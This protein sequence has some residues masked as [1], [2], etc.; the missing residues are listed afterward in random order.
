MV[1]QQGMVPICIHGLA[2]F[3]NLEAKCTIAS[4]PTKN[5]QFGGKSWLFHNKMFRPPSIRV[6]W[7]QGSI[8]NDIFGVDT[9]V[10]FKIGF[11]REKEREELKLSQTCDPM[12][13]I[14]SPLMIPHFELLP[15]HSFVGVIPVWRKHQNPILETQLSESVVCHPFIAME[16]DNQQKTLDSLILTLFKAS[17]SEQDKA[18][19]RPSPLT[20]SLPKIISLN[21]DSSTYNMT[22]DP[23]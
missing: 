9:A 7:L 8:S 4:Y 15:P 1:L 11:I 12:A 23:S 17:D 10:Q 13:E 19:F 16:L 20:G 5:H 18:A 2:V 14:K 3:I 22:W 6:G 21:M